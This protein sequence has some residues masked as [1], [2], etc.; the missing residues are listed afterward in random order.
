[1]DPSLEIRKLS[2]SHVKELAQILETHELWKRLMT[3]IPKTLQKN[4]FVCDV[5]LENPHKY[6]SEHFK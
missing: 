1:M 4:N 3:I 2:P 6:N 5:T